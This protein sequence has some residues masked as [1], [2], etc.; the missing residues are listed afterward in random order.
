MPLRGKHSSAS[1]VT[2]RYVCLCVYVCACVCVCEYVYPCP[3]VYA[4]VCAFMRACL[5]RVCPCIVIVLI[6]DGNLKHEK[7]KPASCVHVCVRMC[8]RL[9]CF[10][11]CVCLYIHSVSFSFTSSSQMVSL[12]KS[13]DSSPLSDAALQATAAKCAITVL[14]TAP[15]VPPPALSPPINSAGMCAVFKCVFSHTITY[16]LVCV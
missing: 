11:L 14:A 13:L 10:F 5:L 7:Q 2:T 1:N 8:F 15:G 6:P 12:K 4:C 9:C 16:A 3:C